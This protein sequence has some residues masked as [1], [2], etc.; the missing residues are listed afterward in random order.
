VNAQRCTER[1]CRSTLF[2]RLLRVGL[3]VL[4]T[5]F[6]GLRPAG[7]VNFRLAA[8]A[9]QPS[10][11]GYWWPMLTTYGYHLYDQTGRFTP[12]LKY[13]QWTGNTQPLAWE[14]KYNMTS[15]PNNNWYGHCN[16]WAAA[17]LMEPD[18]LYTVQ[19]NAAAGGTLQFQRGETEG[20]LVAAHMYDPA[21]VF[22]GARHDQGAN[23]TN[24]LRALDLHKTLLYYLRDHTSG[25]VFN[26]SDQ[27]QVW[28][29]P[30]D[31]FV[32]T[33]TTDS[34]DPGLT[35]VILQLSF[36][37]DDVDPNFTGDQ[38]FFMTYNYWV[39]GSDPQ[40]S[41]SITSADWE[42]NS[43]QHHPQ[44]VWHPAYAASYIPGF[45]QVNTLDY[46]TVHRLDVVASGQPDPGASH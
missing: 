2:P 41:T 42:G 22:L 24:D 31:G 25:L 16:A 21:D 35:H 29:Y 8:N 5:S 27:A 14:T 4:V 20:L 6:A 36:R 19:A 15:D 44:F 45:H 9:K 17:A 7:A 10:W 30:A 11:C 3:L 28:S 18:P 33:G 13:G 37:D 12:L 34:R 26:L 43:V 32:M 23:Y 39:R 1:A 46:S 38:Q 40:T